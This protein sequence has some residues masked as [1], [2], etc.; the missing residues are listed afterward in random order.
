MADDDYFDDIAAGSATALF[1]PS[2]LARSII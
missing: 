1:A 2:L